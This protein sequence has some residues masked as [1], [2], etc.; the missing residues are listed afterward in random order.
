MIGCKARS[1]PLGAM[2]KFVCKGL[3]ILIFYLSV[4]SLCRIIFLGLMS[5]Y[6]GEAVHQQ[7][8]WLALETGTC[9][10]IQTAGLLMLITIVPGTLV[11][12]F[13]AKAQ[14]LCEAVLSGVVL[15]VS[16]IFFFASFPYYQQFHS[17]FNQLFFNA[18]NDDMYALFISLV[19]EFQ[20]PLRLTGAVVMTVAL[21]WL[22]R[23]FL[24]W[25]CQ[26]LVNWWSHQREQLPC[27]TGVQGL[28]LLLLVYVQGSLIVFGGSFS[29]QSAVD[30]E[31][32]GITKD[33]F[34]NE[35]ILDDYQ[36]LYRGY[37]M[38]GRL[39]ACNGLNFT[40]EQI[41]EL[42]G[43]LANKPANSDNLDV[44]LQRYAQGPQIPKPQHIFLIVSE[45]YANWPLLPEYEKLPISRGMRSIIAAPDSDYCPTF[46]PNGSSTVS[47]VTGIVTGLADANL[48]LTTMP[49]SFKEPY[50]TAFAPQMAKLGYAT[51]FWYA[52]PASWE[53]IGAF[54]QAQGF[55]HFYGRGDLPEEATGSVWGAD[56]EFLYQEVL[57]SVAK[58][59]PSFNV[60]LNVSNHSPYNVDLASK[61]I[62]LEAIRAALPPEA[63]ED[64][65]LVQELG[66]Y[67]YADRE[68]TKFIQTIKSQYPDSLIFVVGDHGDRYNIEKTPALYQRYGVPFVITGKGVHPG[69]LA[70]DSAGSQIDIGPTMLELIAPQGFSY[71]A[72]GSSLSRGNNR[73]VNYGFWITRD[74]IGEA[75]RSPLEPVSIGQKSQGLDNEAME[76]YIN[77]VRSLSWWRPK[78]GPILDEE[79]LKGRE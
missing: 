45:S 8:I 12:L 36:A 40:P 37:R 79:L 46:L 14:E 23:K 50:V 4:L 75:D 68:M 63:A 30:W 53:R 73:G 71:S 49:E 78:Y 58:D 72:I 56:D 48:Y 47:A 26:T 76:K 28:L 59:T 11:G 64:E 25:Q 69:L 19:Q 41:R 54:T 74:Y 20:L 67:C 17:R 77:A 18:G 29:W 42:A 66:H 31:N 7:D 70:P 13:S 27:A 22:L 39:L 57:T 34:L 52:G 6:L 3:K 61:G 60:V 32:A 43:Y 51:N 9:L 44:Y 15:L 38:N 16:S 62:D 2:T 65:G 33:A 10:S 55:Q 5:E 21:W 35:V 24:K 1:G